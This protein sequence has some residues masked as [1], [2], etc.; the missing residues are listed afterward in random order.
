MHF[1]SRITIPFFPV[2][3]HMSLMERA[4][5][6]AD[7]TATHERVLIQHNTSKQT[8]SFI[9]CRLNLIKMTGYDNV[10]K[11]HRNSIANKFSKLFIYF[12][13]QM[14]V[15]GILSG[16]I[17]AHDVK[18]D[19]KKLYVS[20]CILGMCAVM[21][22]PQIINVSALL[23]WLCDVCASYFNVNRYLTIKRPAIYLSYN[24]FFISHWWQFI[25]G[26][27]RERNCVITQ[28]GSQ[29][30][31][32]IDTISKC[33]ATVAEL[34]VLYDDTYA[35]WKTIFVH[36]PSIALAGRTTSKLCKNPKKN[37]PTSSLPAV[38]RN[39]I[40]QQEKPRNKRAK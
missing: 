2:Q 32:C 10:C 28:F 4:C 19:V 6:T 39:I 12:H 9:K 33:K 8:I 7:T 30:K 13:F 34:W 22:H 40:C 16:V 25:F 5:W 14:S 23:S 20:C 35:R 36:S 37:N 17:S 21:V 3:I 18:T 29:R 15:T 26:S 1:S 24:R 31:L 38:K 27:D 11:T